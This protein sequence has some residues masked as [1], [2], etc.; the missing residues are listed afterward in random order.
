MHLPMSL[1]EMDVK[2][3]VACLAAALLL[4][5]CSTVANRR[6]D[7][8]SFTGLTTKS[9]AE[10]QTCFAA[11]TDKGQTPSYLPKANGGTYTFDLRGYVLWVVDIIDRGADRQVTVHEINSMW[12]KNTHTAKL[13]QQCL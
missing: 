10:F 3:L 1:V 11:V 7:P 6:D 13:V 9:L 8:P 2:R 5:S 4:S 12:G